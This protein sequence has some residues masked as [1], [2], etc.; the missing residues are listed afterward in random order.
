MRYLCFLYGPFT[1]ARYHSLVIE[2]ESFPS[3]VLEITAWTEDG[4]CP[5]SII[6]IGH[7]NMIEIEIVLL[8][9]AWLGDDWTEIH[10]FFWVNAGSS[11]Q[12]HPE[13]I[14]TSEGKTLVRN[15]V[16]LIERNEAKSKN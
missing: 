15:F 9:F 2:K 7:K 3:D 11:V 13:S 6:F 14:I 4:G 10:G 1:A 12:F 8:H 5:Y 16:K